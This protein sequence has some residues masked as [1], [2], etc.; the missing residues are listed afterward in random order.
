MTMP[1]PKSP[2]GGAYKDRY[3]VYG[4]QLIT[5]DEQILEMAPHDP[6]W[7]F[8]IEEQMRCQAPAIRFLM[9]EGTYE[10]RYSCRLRSVIA[11]AMRLPAPRCPKGK[12]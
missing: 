5:T 10:Q 1:D 7:R 11:D 4:Q 8:L 9:A 6:R 3:A 12:D 2:T